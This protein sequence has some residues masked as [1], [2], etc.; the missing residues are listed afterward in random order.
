MR[1]R[2]SC[3]QRAFGLAASFV[4]NCLSA[5]AY[6]FVGQNF[7]SKNNGKQIQIVYGIQNTPSGIVDG[8]YIAKDYIGNEN[9]VLY[10]GDNIF[11]D[12]ISEDIKKFKDGAVVF[13]KKVKDPE[14]FGVATL[15]SQGTIIDITEKPSKP[16]SDLAVVGVYIYDNTV[17]DK[18][19]GQKPSA[20]GEY[21]IT[22]VNK[23]YIQEKKLRAALLKK[24]WIDIGTFDSLIQA[25]NYMK[26]KNGKDHR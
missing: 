2:T 7:I 20:R 25:S 1:A 13:L 5:T 9:C 11:E 17:F 22:Y 18:M 3:G 24:E 10:L 4:K 23:K 21:E 14:R 8:L 12:D 19:I 16:K 26:Q 15:D 6:V